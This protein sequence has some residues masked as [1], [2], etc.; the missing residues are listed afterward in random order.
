M[1]KDLQKRW[2]NKNVKIK[3]VDLK[4]LKQLYMIYN[5]MMFITLN[6]YWNDNSRYEN[7]MLANL[8][9]RVLQTSMIPN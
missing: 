8:A 9:T 7:I 1:R 5:K 6:K 3:K 4:T 2:K